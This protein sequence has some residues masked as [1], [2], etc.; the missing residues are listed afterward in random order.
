MRHLRMTLACQIE[1]LLVAVAFA[2]AATARAVEVHGPADSDGVHWFEEMVPMPDGTK[3][4]TYGSAPKEG[5]KCA[6]VVLRNPYVKE[7]R[8][9]VAKWARG[10]KRALSRGYAYVFQQCRGCGM[11]EGDWIPYENERSDG[12]ALLDFVRRLPWY[13]GE[14]YLQGGSYGASVH[15]AYLD[16]NPSD[17]KGAALYVQDVN[18]FNIAYRNG[19]FKIGLHGGWFLKGYKKKNRALMRDKSATFYQF[20]LVDFPRRHWG[21]SVPCMENVLR[22][23]RGDDP[24]WS[25]DAPGSGADYRNA[26]ARSTMPILLKTGFYDIYTEGV[27]DMWR[28]TSPDRLASCALLVDACDHGGAP[29]KKLEG[30]K[31]VFPGGARRD[32]GVE[33]LDWFDSIRGRLACTNAPR[34]KVRYYALW[35]NAWH[36]AATLEDGPREVRLRIGCGIREYSYDPT[37]PPP[38][39]PGSGGIAFGGMQLQPKPDFRDD[40]ASFVMQPIAERLD[41]RGRMEARLSVESDCDDTCFYVRVSVDKGD[42]RWYL[43]RDDITSLAHGSPYRP[44]ERRI[45][46]FKF[47]D[48]AFRLDRGDR[49]R[50]D[51]SSASSQFAPHPNVAGDAFSVT[52]PRT[53]HN[54]VFADASELVLRVREAVDRPAAR[55]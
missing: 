17:V 31:G 16:T 51:V 35:E 9:D 3:L 7:E 27:L 30:T 25:S 36:E 40:V 14:I 50:V 26:F 10:Q 38:S 4:Y 28:E 2:V 47:A 54:K 19:F 46:P 22:H 23:P 6:I 8:V 49:L 37:R 52:A 41:V 20:P 44:G 11:S 42:G 13:D 48:H 55:D 5:G 39:F 1:M 32:E 43:L 12:L 24:F 53:A 29:N 33:A 21:E 45:V 34:G 18:R 15:W